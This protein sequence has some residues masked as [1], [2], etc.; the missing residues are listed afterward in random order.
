MDEMIKQN[1]WI[2]YLQWLFRAIIVLSI[3]TA[4]VPF[5]VTNRDLDIRLEN[6]IGPWVYWY[7][8]PTLIVVYILLV[9]L[10]RFYT[11][12]YQA[13]ISSSK[14]ELWFLLAYICFWLFMIFL[15]LR[16]GFY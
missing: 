7:S 6:F 14:T 12:D 9:I 15:T 8:V 4:L 2:K 11:K 3:V 5:A 13:R 16:Y 10:R 1:P